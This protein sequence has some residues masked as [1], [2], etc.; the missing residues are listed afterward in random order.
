MHISPEASHIDPNLRITPPAQIPAAEEWV[1]LGT[2]RQKFI[3]IHEPI[4]KLAIH[5]VSKKH[6]EQEIEQD[7]KSTSES[8]GEA[9]S[10]QNLD[11]ISSKQLWFS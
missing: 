7:T 8:V 6:N 3:S 5:T 4:N 9:E 1:D 10:D 11:E 2:S